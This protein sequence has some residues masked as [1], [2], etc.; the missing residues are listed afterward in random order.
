MYR[1]TYSD[2]GKKVQITCKDENTYKRALY[3]LWEY[4]YV[5][6]ADVKNISIKSV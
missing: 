2:E 1:I 3:Y 5:D 6:L 4:T